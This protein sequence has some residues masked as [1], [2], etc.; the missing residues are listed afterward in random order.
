MNN[1]TNSFQAATAAANAA[2]GAFREREDIRTID[3]IIEMASRTGNDQDRDSVISKL[4]SRVSPERR[5]DA[6]RVVQRREDEIKA[7]KEKAEKK[8]GYKAANLPE[9]YAALDAPVVGKLIDA[10][11]PKAPPGGL[12][13]QPVDPNVSAAIEE[14]VKNNPH[15]SADEL[16][17]AFDKSRIPRTYSG[18]YV[19][20]RR[21]M[22]ETAAK[23]ITE[24]TKQDRGEQLRFHDQSAKYDEELATTARNAKKQIFAV[25]QIGEAIDTNNID[26]MSMANIFSAFGDVGKRFAD[27]FINEDQAKMQS[28]IPYLLEGWKEVFGVRLSDADL[29]ILETKLPSI[30][31]TPEANRAILSVLKKYGLLAQLRNDIGQ[32]IKKSN[33]GLRPLD[34]VDQVETRYDEMTVPV[35][36]INP[37]NGKTISIPAYLLS[38]ALA[39]GAKLA[40]EAGKDE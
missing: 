6:L 2:G 18:S 28:N 35:K 20:N 39:D 1:Q 27:A 8:A 10:G 21:R 16:Q 13:G 5:P 14:V 17:V 34:Y 40:N 38:A 3:K 7:R 26:P 36:I 15:A 12:G 23:N 29:K 32:E 30:G 37:R 4:L 9:E 25:E 11:T 19:E 33:G 22:D 24:K 31:K